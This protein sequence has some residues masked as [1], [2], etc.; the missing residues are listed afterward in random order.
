MRSMRE[1]LLLRAPTGR[2]RLSV[3]LFLWLAAAAA[4][5]ITY[6]HVPTTFNWIDP[7]GHTPVVWSNPSLC[8]GF[9]DVIGDDSIT[10]PVNIGFSFPFGGSSYTQLSVMT[11][12]RLQFAGNTHCGAGTQNIGPPRTY[13]LPYA[14]GNLNNTMKVYGADLDAS[15]NGSGGGPEPTTCPAPTCAVL[16]TATP[17]G[18]PPNRQFVVTWLA[19]P[20]WASTASFY[21]LQVILNEDG[22]FVFQ[23]G[24]SNNPDGGHADIGWE[25]TST[26]F[27]TVSYSDIGSLAST[28]ILFF[29]PLIATPTPTPTQTPTP[30]PTATPTLTPT[31]TPTPT[32]TNTPTDTPTQTP[33]NTPTATPTNTPTATPT[34][35]PTNTPTLTP[36]NTPTA[37]PTATPTN[38][39]TAD[40]DQHAATDTRR[41]RRRI[42]RPT[43]PTA[44]PTNTPTDT[45]TQ[46][47]TATPTS[48]PTPTATPTA[49]PTSTPTQTP[50]ATPT[51]YAHADGDSD[52][53]AHDQPR[54]RRRPPP[55]P[56]RPRPRRRRRR[57]RTRTP[58]ST[59]TPTATRTPTATP[60]PTRT[61]TPGNPKAVQL[62]V[63]VHASGGP[64]N[65]NGVLESGETVVVEPAWQNTTV[66]TQAFSGVASSFVG[67]LGPVYTVDDNAADYG[68]VDPGAT[69]DCYDATPARD[70]YAMTISGARPAAHWDSTFDETLS[71]GFPK[72][73]TLHVGESFP[74]VPVSHLFYVFIENL[75]HNGVTVGYTDGNYH[76]G[77]SITRAQMAV[78]VLKGKFGSSHVPPP[79]TGTVFGDVSI[80]TFAASWIE[81]L[82]ALQI[83]AGC[84]GGNYCPDEPVTRGQ[85]AAFLLK[86]EHGSGYAPPACAGAFADVP[87]PGSPGFPYSDWIEQLYAEAITA[88]CSTAPPGGLPSYCPASPNTRGEM[89]VF[90]VK[91][92]GLLLYGP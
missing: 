44:T 43:R 85:M 15:P 30:T 1:G 35:T 50:T 27:D 54:P 5:A 65:L 46:T 69:T 66:S 25:L 75:F 76:P 87:C 3:S 31:N 49:T 51:S 19:T 63:D 55:R 88:G 70:C 68:T 83:T 61:P 59:P 72:T 26:D 86:T 7:S 73:W 71:L 81:E 11:N 57:R 22:S 40:A 90:I 6:S 24:P 80:G 58:T 67:P 41:I 91:T 42:P 28:A 53:D 82:A 17:L 33:T 21:N 16:Y 18:S 12:G 4:G 84:A 29:N 20:D 64:S 39:P 32:P 23:Y 48:T 38:T 79:A 62:I 37:T 74:D 34:A 89:A 8:S 45:P 9:G 52:R 13:T 10:A 60:T 14:S 36:T 56:V 77:D 2:R 78:F 92:F 47:P